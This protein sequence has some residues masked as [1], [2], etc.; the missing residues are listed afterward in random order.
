MEECVSLFPSSPRFPR[1]PSS[2]PFP[3]FLIPPLSLVSP[4]PRC[5]LPA[6]FGALPGWH[7]L[8]GEGRERGVWPLLF[9]VL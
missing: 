2:P 1:L 9:L 5:P 4:F 7:F 6:R 8:E 3:S